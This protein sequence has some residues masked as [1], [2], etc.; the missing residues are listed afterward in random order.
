MGCSNCKQKIPNE[1]RK[2]LMKSFE[3]SSKLGIWIVIIW[4]S[5]GFYGLFTLIS[6]FL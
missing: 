3:G 4:T 5:L 2:E 1:T 6:K